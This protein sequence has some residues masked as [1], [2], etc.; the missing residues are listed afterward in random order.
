MIACTLRLGNSSGRMNTWVTY[1]TFRCTSHFA[2]AA[3]SYVIP[4]AAMTGSC[5]RSCAHT[6]QNQV[7]E[8]GPTIIIRHLSAGVTTPPA[9]PKIILDLLMLKLNASCHTPIDCK[10][11]T[12]EIILLDGV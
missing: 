2:I 11:T 8:E 7:Y 4:S 1:D 5:I 3:L 12:F 6:K 10:R 9:W